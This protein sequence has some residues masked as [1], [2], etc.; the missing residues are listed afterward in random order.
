MAT[1]RQNDFERRASARSETSLELEVS[2]IDWLTYKVLISNVSQSG[3]L[4]SS[5]G[6]LEVGQSLSFALPGVGVRT[7]R[8]VRTGLFR[9]YGCQFDVP[10]TEKELSEVLGPSSTAWVHLGKPAMT[11]GVALS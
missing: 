5:A 8:I 1:L 7:A 9:R 2:P 3:L 4:I 11:A 10:L 6:K